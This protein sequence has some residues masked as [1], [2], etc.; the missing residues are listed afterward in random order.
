MTSWEWGLVLGLR[1]KGGRV[2]M[3]WS[4]AQGWTWAKPRVRLTLATERRWV[5]LELRC[6]E[7]EAGRGQAGARLEHGQGME[8][9]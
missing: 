9:V 4:Q 6:S 8:A 5:L 2:G 1:T 7:S 3:K